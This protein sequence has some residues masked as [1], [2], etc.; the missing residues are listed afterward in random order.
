MKRILIGIL[1]VWR[2]KVLGSY[3]ETWHIEF[4]WKHQTNHFWMSKI[5]IWLIWSWNMGRTTATKTYPTRS[6]Y[7]SDSILAIRIST[8]F[9]SCIKTRRALQ[10]WV[11]INALVS[12]GPP[13]I[14]Q[15]RHK[16]LFAPTRS[17]AEPV[18]IWSEKWIEWLI[19]R[20]VCEYV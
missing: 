5:C 3:E 12:R 14:F 16:T 15:T 6:N 11:L 10:R 19:Y 9:R 13:H 18:S 8:I 4:S 20:Y 7:P 2:F 1:R 17:R